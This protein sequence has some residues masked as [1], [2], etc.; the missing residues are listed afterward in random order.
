VKRKG[1]TIILFVIC[2][3]VIGI[4]CPAY[5]QQ[6]E[7]STVSR[8]EKTTANNVSKGDL[9]EQK[10][11]LEIEELERKSRLGIFDRP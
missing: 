4:C 8:G 1:L 2:S 5:A 11:K 6:V 3:A 10:L 9:E 7:D